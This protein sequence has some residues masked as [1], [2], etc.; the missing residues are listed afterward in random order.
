MHKQTPWL[1]LILVPGPPMS[2]SLSINPCN[3]HMLTKRSFYIAH[4]RAEESVGTEYQGQK[5]Q[6]T[7]KNRLPLTFRRRPQ[8]DRDPARPVKPTIATHCVKHEASLQ[9]RMQQ[10]LTHIGD[11]VSIIAH[12]PIVARPTIDDV[13]HIINHRLHCLSR[14]GEC[15]F[16]LL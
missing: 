16:R 11:V 10:A 15:L 9:D 7:A 14:M 2:V 8:G 3:L 5:P 1:P 6:R 12:D 13:L 4:T